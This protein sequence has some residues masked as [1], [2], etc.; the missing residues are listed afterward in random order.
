MQF[1]SVIIP[2]YNAGKYLDTCL[3][4]VVNQTYKNLE[5]LLIDDGSTDGS[6][7]L[8][9]RYADQDERIKVFHKKNGG[10]SSARNLGLQNATGD[11]ISFVDS[12]DYLELNL[13]ETLLNKIS[14]TPCDIISFEY[15]INYPDKETL[16]K[17][18]ESFYG[19]FPK[20]QVICGTSAVNGFPFTKMFRRTL[21]D[22]WNM[23]NVQ[24]M[25][26]ELIHFPLRFD[27]GIARGE[28]SLFNSQ[29]VHCADKILV[30][31]DPLYH[32][33]QSEESACR[34]KFRPSQLTFVRLKDFYVP[35][36]EKYYPDRLSGFYK[37][38][39]EL[40]IGIYCDM[41][42]DVENYDKEMKNIFCVFREC[43]AKIGKLSIK[44][45][46]KMQCF[47][48]SPRLFCKIHKR[49]WKIK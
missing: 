7:V 32:Y 47:R 20:E 25:G 1:I 28:D 44:Q 16:H 27:E 9:D 37:N 42:N 5:I 10:V 18:D 19:I 3:H 35:Y 29:I 31:A 33:V 15:F 46:L 4:T 24:T 6:G 14:A 48:F 22:G 2:V 17:K 21:L 45:K 43:Y 30:I 34:G 36:Y 41:Y 23:C 38:F 12:D 26:D 13:Y 39:C 11:W 8:C 49:L 40:I